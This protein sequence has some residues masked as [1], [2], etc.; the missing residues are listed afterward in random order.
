MKGGLGHGPY[1]YEYWRE[2]RRT[3]KRYWG[4][5]RP[6]PRDFHQDE[7]REQAYGGRTY[8]RARMAHNADMGLLGLS[9]GFTSADLKRAYRA[10]ALLHHPDRGGDLET[11]KKINVAYARLRSTIGR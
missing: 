5:K 3:R 4:R 10:A 9:E 6:S 2:G 11:M 1:W 8:D 7:Q